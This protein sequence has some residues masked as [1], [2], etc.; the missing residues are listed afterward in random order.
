MKSP[1]GRF[2]RAGLL[3][4]AALLALACSQ[5]PPVH[6]YVLEVRPQGERLALRGFIPPPSR[7]LLGSA[8]L[9]A[10][11]A[12]RSPEERSPA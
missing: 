3:T 5:M 7:Q 4:G 9:K 12:C 6:F 10:A 8:V 2:T 1:M 11:I